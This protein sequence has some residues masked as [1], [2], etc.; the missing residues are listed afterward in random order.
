MLDPVTSGEQD[1][2]RRKQEAYSHCLTFS[3]FL[4][5]PHILSNA[6]LDDELDAD[7]FKG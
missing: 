7:G 4:C 5:Q 3:V 1:D 6:F 2:Q